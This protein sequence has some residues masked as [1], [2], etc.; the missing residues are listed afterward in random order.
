MNPGGVERLDAAGD[1]EEPDRLHE[2]RFAKPRHLEQLPAGGKWPVLGPP[3]VQ[4]AGRG[5]IE[6]RHVAEQRRTRRVHVDAHIVDATLHDRIERRMEV[7]R[8]DVVLVEADADVG[9]IDLHQHRE[10]IQQP[11]A[12][13]DRPADGGLVPGQFLA[14]IAA[15]RIDAG[16]RLVDDNVGDVEF[17]QPSR[18]QFGHE[19]LGFPAGGTVADGHHRAGM[20]RDHF[21]DLVRGGGP[22][23]RLADNVEHRMLERVAAFIDRHG[24]AAALEAGIER[25]H[26]AAG[27]RGLQEQVSQVSGKH[28]HGMRF[29]IFGHLPA[30]F[31]FEARQHQPGKRVADAALEEFGMGMAG[32]HQHLLGGRLHLIH[33]PV[34]PHLQELGPLAPVDRQHAVWRHPLHML[35]IVKEVA[36]MLLVLRLGL[37]RTLHPLAREAGLAVQDAPQPLPH[38]GVFAEVVGDDVADAEQHVGHARHLSIGVEEIGRPFVEVGGCGIGRKNLPCQRLEPPLPGDLGERQLAGLERQVEILELLGT[39]GRGDPALQGGS[40]PPLTLNRAEDGLLPIGQLTGA[41]HALGDQTDAHLIEPAGL[42]ATVADDERNGVALIEQA[43][44]RLDRRYRQPDALG[45]RP[46]IDE[47]RG[48]HPTGGCR[49]HTGFSRP[50]NSTFPSPSR[51]YTRG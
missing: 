47:R 2:R 24:L 22:L 25:E 35:G 10:R 26:A 37:A 39:R 11:T 28:L 18:H 20:R 15:G 1:L 43:H 38:V 13:R 46:Q 48:S 6:A 41:T 7:P 36:K 8:L 16:A 17:L 27:H 32:G 45:D 5:L 19:C 23:F 3:F 33:R 42:V 49:C 9:R 51:T 14:G 31:A 40:Q 29:A 50:H 34:D 44:R 21:D 30:E 12:D 4:V